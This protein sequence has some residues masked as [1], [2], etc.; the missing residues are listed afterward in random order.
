[1]NLNGN[2]NPNVVVGKY[3]PNRQAKTELN[4]YAQYLFPGYVD[5]TQVPMSPGD[6]QVPVRAE[7]IRQDPR[8]NPLPANVHSES[9]SPYNVQSVPVEQISSTAN[10][11]IAPIKIPIVIELTINL[12]INH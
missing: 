7:P 8:N 12:N 3:D 4:D 5:P 11:S 10:T 9:A 1:M 6:T 2:H